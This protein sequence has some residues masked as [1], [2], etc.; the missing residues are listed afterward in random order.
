M[1]DNDSIV[2][3][4]RQAYGSVARQALEGPTDTSCSPGCCV[5]PRP[6]ASASLGYDSADLAKVPEG[7]NLGLGCGNPQRFA[8]LSVGQTVL[9]LGSGGGLDCF[10]AAEK[11]GEEGRVIGIDM[12]ADM[13]SLA[14]R[15]QG[16]DHPQVSFRLGEIEH[17]P[18]GDGEVD[19][20]ISNCVFNLSPNKGQV[21]REA[22][23]V[24]RP[25]GRLAIGDVVAIA[26]L[27]DRLK[28]SMDAYAGCIGGASTVDELRQHLEAAGFSEIGVEVDTQMREAIASWLPG[29]G[30]EDIVASAR[31]TATKPGGKSCCAPSCCEEEPASA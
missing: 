21:M 16:P 4:V 12:T 27:P 26:P 22:Y 10:L 24:L 15:N 17:L 9:D 19:V 30:L 20:I 31:I 29:Q 28:Q 5:A 11:V 23:R 14:R 13:V 3:Q 8:D 18:V 1:N 6:D 7:A 2:T 25:G